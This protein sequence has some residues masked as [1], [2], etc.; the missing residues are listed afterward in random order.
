MASLLI[1]PPNFRRTDSFTFHISIIFSRLVSLLISI[2]RWDAETTKTYLR[3][4]IS[5][6]SGFD[7]D[8]RLRLALIIVYQSRNVWEGLHAETGEVDN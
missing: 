3:R 1:S 7:R 8:E 6:A 4:L 2:Y 5:E